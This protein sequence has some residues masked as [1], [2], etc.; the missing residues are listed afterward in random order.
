MQP[1]EPVELNLSSKE[2]QH[3]QQALKARYWFLINVACESK[4]NSKD[5]LELAAEVKDLFVKMAG[6]DSSLV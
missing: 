2:K 1:Y 6:K 5:A 4:E 3:I